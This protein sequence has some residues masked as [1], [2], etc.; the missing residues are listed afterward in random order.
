MKALLTPPSSSYQPRTL[1]E[2]LRSEGKSVDDQITEIQ[3]A[4]E[5]MTR[6]IDTVGPAGGNEIMY[7]T[8]A[9]HHRL[10][11]RL[12]KQ[13]NAEWSEYYRE[14]VAGTSYE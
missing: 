3:E 11:E 8:I 12:L 13:R 1:S 10:I 9:N 14:E 6:W 4:I 2:G 7:A 5:D